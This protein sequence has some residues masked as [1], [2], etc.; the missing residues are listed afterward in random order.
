MSVKIPEGREN[1]RGNIGGGE[2]SVEIP[3]GG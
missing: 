1:V 2:M 3:E